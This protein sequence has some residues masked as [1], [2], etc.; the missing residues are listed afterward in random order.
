MIS[1]R[2]DLFKRLKNRDKRID[3]NNAVKKMHDMA[4]GHDI[5]EFEF[6][7][8]NIEGIAYTGTLQVIYDAKFISG[9]RPSMYDP[10]EPDSYEISVDD[11]VILPGEVFNASTDEEVTNPEMLVNLAEAIGEAVGGV[12]GEAVINAIEEHLEAR[13]RDL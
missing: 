4:Q 12:E 7:D 8:V 10:G 9:S 2:S 13:D 3:Y 1:C 11:I 6:D 5:Y